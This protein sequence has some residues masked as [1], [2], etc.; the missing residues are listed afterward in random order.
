MTTRPMH[1][2]DYLEAGGLACPYCSCRAITIHASKKRTD[3]HGTTRTPAEC[4]DCSATWEQLHRK[5]AV[6]PSRFLLIGYDPAPPSRAAPGF[7]AVDAAFNSV[8]GAAG[9]A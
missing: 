2:A 6:D 7:A 8:F 1:A 5:S 3:A 9:N 4:G